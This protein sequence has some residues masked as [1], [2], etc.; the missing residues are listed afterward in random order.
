L[1]VRTNLLL[2]NFELFSQN[3]SQKH[4]KLHHFRGNFEK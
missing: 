2:P 3:F 4:K 1:A